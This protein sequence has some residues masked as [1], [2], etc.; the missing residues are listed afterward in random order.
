MTLPDFD[1]ACDY[2]RVFD[3]V[4]LFPRNYAART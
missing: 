2:A 4:F 3:Y 1:G